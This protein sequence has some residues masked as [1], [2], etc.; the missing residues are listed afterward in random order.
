MISPNTISTAP[1]NNP[2]MRTTLP[3]Y[4]A[5]LHK[6]QTPREESV[7]MLDRHTNLGL[8]LMQHLADNNQAVEGTLDRQVWAMGVTGSNH[9]NQLTNNLHTLQI[10]RQYPR[11]EFPHMDKHQL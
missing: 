8:V 4:K 6:H 10:G 11:Q 9:N 3:P 2:T 7:N 5:G 1:I